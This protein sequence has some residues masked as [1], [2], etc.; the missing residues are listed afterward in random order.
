MRLRPQFACV[1]AL[2]ALLSPSGR[3]QVGPP[4]PITIHVHASQP[5]GPYSPHL[6][7]LRRRRAQLHL[8]AGRPQTPQRALRPQLR[9][10]LLPHAQSLHHRQR[11]RLAEMGLDQRV[12]GKARRHARLRL[13]HHRPHLRHPRRRARPPAGRDRLHAR[14]AL[15]AP[16]ALPP[17]IPQRRHLHRLDLSAEG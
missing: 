9:S 1:V 8:R 15:D 6:Q 16:R 13:H 7:L 10:R 17:H 2:A 4:D 12:H 3:A 14:S 5:T 11:R